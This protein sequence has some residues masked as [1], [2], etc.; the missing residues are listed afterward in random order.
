[1]VYNDRVSHCYPKRA[2]VLINNAV[3]IVT[4]ASAGIGQACATNL[5]HLG[6]HVIC[7]ARRHERLLTLQ[8]TLPGEHAIYAGDISDPATMPAVVAL[9]IATFGRIDAIV[10]NAGIGL[11]MPVAQLQWDDVLRCMNVN[12][13]GVLSGF[14]AVL[15]HFMANK[16]GAIV[17]ISS[18]VGVH[19]LPYSGGYAASKGALERLCDALRTELLGS[20]INLTVVRPG[21]V[22][23]DFFS[24]RLGQNNEIR[25]TRSVGIPA[26]QVANR[27]IYALTHHPRVL[28]TRWQDRLL[29]WGSACFP[30]LADRL[31][32]K[33]IRW[34]E[35]DSVYRHE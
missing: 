18:V 34:Q 30:S 14:Q 22:Q 16:S 8:H 19:A 12:V 11:S 3:I 4:G 35:V 5:A 15:P 32:A 27:I 24:H 6:A 25:R 23:S 9:A 28:Y 10:C 13:G 17:V 20:G 2:P 29:L 7:V 1:M 26:S 33:M 21:T 31:L